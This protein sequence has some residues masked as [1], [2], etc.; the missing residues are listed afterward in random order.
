[1]LENMR[2]RTTAALAASTLLAAGAATAAAGRLARGRRAEPGGTFPAGFA[3]A[4]LTVHAT[5][6]GQVTLTRSLD[7]LRPGRYGLT[8]PGCHAV[9]G[10]LL[11]VPTGADTVVRR[12][13]HVSRGALTPGAAV[14]LTPQLH[15][16][17]PHQALGLD[18]ADVEIS[19]E[20]GP[21]PGWF[22]PGP[23]DTWIIALH[24]LGATREHPLNVLPLY[25]RL[26]F[27]A[28][29]PAYRADPS[30]TAG[31]GPDDWLDADAAL[32]YAVRHGARRVVL[33]G[34]SSGA[35]LALHTAS[36][37]PLRGRIAGLVLDSPVLDPPAT[38]RA[39]GVRRGAVRPLARLLPPLRRDRGG[40]YP[41]GP[42]PDPAQPVARPAAD[43][44]ARPGGPKDAPFPV[45]LLHGPGDCV[46]SF[47]ASRE[48]A[49]RRPDA[50]VLHTVPDAEHAAM[51]NAAPQEYE[52]T[53]RRFLTPL[54]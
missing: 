34:W 41:A 35:A 24:G 33:H 43:P 17:G 6:A 28:L 21:L 54:M 10:D 49:A 31:L 15:E 19:S 22:V 9:V 13:E 1:M 5:A 42:A 26:R 38:L 53:L 14:T 40:A 30:V 51:W 52:E 45:L 50:V 25:H 7:S 29:I 3:G 37:S 44:P 16:G 11:D 23:R 8:S 20:R 46:A 12:L 18:A 47:D 32:R 27:S 2:R 4:R 36:R 39:L 48:F